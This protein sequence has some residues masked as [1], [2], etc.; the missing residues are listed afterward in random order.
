MARPHHLI[1][2]IITI[3]IVESTREPLLV[4]QFL[5]QMRKPLESKYRLGQIE[6]A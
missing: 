5:A 6:G 3:T 2:S 4:H 1:K